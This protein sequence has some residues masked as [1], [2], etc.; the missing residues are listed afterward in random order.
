M[1]K[2]D[3]LEAWFAKSL[4][5]TVGQDL[6]KSAAGDNSTRVA[7][8]GWILKR[9][10]IQPLNQPNIPATKTGTTKASGTPTQVGKGTSLPK[11][12]RGANAPAMPSMIRPRDRFP[13]SQ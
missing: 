11:K 8:I 13:Q 5:I 1:T 7:I 4:E 3:Y 10:I 9:V 12:M 6:G 2:P